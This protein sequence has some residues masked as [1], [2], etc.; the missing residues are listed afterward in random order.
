M[1]NINTEEIDY[2]KIHEEFMQM[3]QRELDKKAALETLNTTRCKEC[4]FWK[5]IPEQWSAEGGQLGYCSIN[6]G[7]WQEGE[8]CSRGISKTKI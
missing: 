5:E 6:R 2:N 3:I 8:F 7:R 1:K 4:H